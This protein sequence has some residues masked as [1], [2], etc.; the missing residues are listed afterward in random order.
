MAE[1]VKTI[2]VTDTLKNSY[3]YISK[4]ER[5]LRPFWLINF[6]FC[7]AY[8]FL[9]GG[10]SNP[11][12]LIWSLGYYIFWCIFFRVYYQK[13]PYF[14]ATK[15]CASAVPSSKMIFITF[16][17]L[18]VLLILPFV[19]LLLGFH[20]KYLL[21]F[22]RYM[23]MLQMP[24]TSVL[25]VL[26]FSI[27]FLMISPFAFCRPYLAWISALQGYS[28]SIRKVF[29]KTAG[30]NVKF[31]SLI[32]LLNLPCFLAYGADVLLRCHG[33]FSVGF[34]SIY[35]IYFNIVFAKVYDFF[36]DVK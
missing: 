15:I 32:F 3:V 36:Y 19:P 10:F 2:Q 34:Y 6:L 4:N 28:G 30:N 18:F 7:G 13:K 29:K 35:L 9:P 20:N 14:C 8:N 27:I 1:S 12:S 22:E 23:A 26:I 31:L 21:V 17:L 5:I 33:W 16:G 11:F 25:N 24:E